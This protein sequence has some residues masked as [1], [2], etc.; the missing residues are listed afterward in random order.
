NGGATNQSGN[1]I[2]RMLLDDITFAFPPTYGNLTGFTFS[3]AN[4]NSTAVSARARVRFYNDNGS[5][6]PGT[7]L[8]GYSFTLNPL[9]AGSVTLLTYNVP[10]SP[11][12]PFPATQKIWAGITF[13]NNGGATGATAA[14]L[15]NLGVGLFD[16]PTIG[17]S[18]DQFF[19]TTAAGS[20]LNINN[21]AGSIIT[22]TGNPKYNAG[23]SFT[24]SVPEP[25]SLSLLLVGGLFASCGVRR[26]LA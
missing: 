1:T 24:T 22:G 11:P 5:N 14:Q 3:V 9:A 12:A 16:P 18:D 17:S 2:T 26:R 8:T 15:D 21:P 23:W 25:G 13:D 10:P 19:L 7:Y 4:L 6:A 20:F